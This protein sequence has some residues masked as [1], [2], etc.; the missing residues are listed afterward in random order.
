MTKKEM[1]LPLREAS[2][3]LG[4]IAGLLVRQEAPLAPLTYFR[5]GG[6]ADLL[7]IPRSIESLIEL[8]R[9]CSREGWPL[10]VFGRATN[11]LVSDRGIRGITALLSPSLGGIR[12]SGD[13]LICAA[14]VPLY[15]IAA[16]AAREELAGFEFACGI[17][18]S[19]GGAIF[20][21]AGAFD[22]S[23][24]EVVVRTAYIDA[25][26]ECWE[27][28]GEEHDFAYRHSFFSDKAGAIILESELGL[29]KGASAA[30]YESMG[31]YAR[32]RYQTQPLAAYSAGSAFRRPAGHFAGKLIT[33]A[34]MKGYTRGRAGVSAKHAG[35]I[36][37][38]GGATSL[39]ILQIFLDVRQAVFEGTGL[40]LIP[41]VRLVGDWEGDPFA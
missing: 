10:S 32:R 33:E 27:I 4:S 6:P 18:G 15:E 35:F 2:Q 37:N 1:N 40:K 29:K 3:A 31:D 41:E 20:M 21:N 16:Y 8:R 7:V 36:V 24:A 19:I 30:I 26:G 14:G 9:L 23:M 13:S 38:H 28:R 34:G 22:G 39:E 25:E 12:R 11:I 5:S 17:P